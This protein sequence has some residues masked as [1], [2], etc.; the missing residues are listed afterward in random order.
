VVL[1]IGAFLLVIGLFLALN[2]VIMD[3]PIASGLGLAIG[4][5]VVGAGMLWWASR[6]RERAFDR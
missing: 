3:E 5:A 2:T 6:E 1:L 4:L